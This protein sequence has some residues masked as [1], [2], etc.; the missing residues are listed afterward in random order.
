MQEKVERSI[1]KWLGYLER[2]DER[3]ITK[4][5]YKEGSKMGSEGREDVEGYGVQLSIRGDLDFRSL[6]D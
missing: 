3:R 4:N 2:M 1:L 6:I 5:L